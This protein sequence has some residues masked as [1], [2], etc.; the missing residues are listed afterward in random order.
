[1]SDY[2]ETVRISLLR[3]DSEELIERIR[4][5]QLT[6]EAKVVAEEILANR[7][8]D[9]KSEFILDEN[10]SKADDFVLEK[11]VAYVGF[12]KVMIFIWM[13]TAFLFGIS[14]SVRLSGAAS[15]STSVVMIRLVQGIFYFIVT[16]VIVG[17]YAYVKR[18]NITT[19]EE[20][21]KK[22][23][24]N[25]KLIIATN[26]IM[27]ALMVVDLFIGVT[28]VFTLIDVAIVGSLTIAIFNNI[29]SAKYILATYA[30]INPLIF[31]ISGYGGT[32]A[33]MWTF[34]FLSC[35]QS[36]TNEKRISN[37]LITA[38]SLMK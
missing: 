28:N 23:N 11:D 30:F 10:T 20:V 4:K 16:G 8:V 7:G 5:N 1:M 26:I 9:S 33:I 6:D 15:N 19:K 31:T 36:I 21:I 38:K 18:K 24:S 14:L 32:A 35:C 13:I 12:P 37:A 27:L 3:L 2:K 34:V 17:I 25:I 22:I 29:K